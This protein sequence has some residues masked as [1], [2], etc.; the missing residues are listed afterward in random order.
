MEGFM[1]YAVTMGLGAMMYIPSF[2][3][4]YLAI[5]KLMGGCTDIQTA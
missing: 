2:I 3:K 1:K 4:I 5:Q